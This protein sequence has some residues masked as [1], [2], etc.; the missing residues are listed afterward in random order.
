MPVTIQGSTGQG[1]VPRGTFDTMN[2]E[3]VTVVIVADDR[4]LVVRPA[5]AQISNLE[6]VQSN[7]VREVPPDD[8][9]ASWVPRELDGTG[10]FTLRID[11]ERAAVNGAWVDKSE[12]RQALQSAAWRLR[13]PREAESEA[14]RTDDR[15]PDCVARWPGAYDGGYDPRC[16]RFPKSCSASC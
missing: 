5:P 14:P 8:P 16:C 1:S 12:A 13:W 4:A 7:N 11:G 15:D 6:Y 3:S 9:R 10:T 2:I